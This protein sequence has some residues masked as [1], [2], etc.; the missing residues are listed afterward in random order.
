VPAYAEQRPEN[1][2]ANQT[3]VTKQVWQWNTGGDRLQPYYD[4]ITGGCYG[5][6][7]QI[8]EWSARKWGF[9][10]IGYPD[11]GKAMAV[12]ESNWRQSPKGDY[13]CGGV[14]YGIDWGCDYQ[15][16]GILQVKRSIWPGAWTQSKD[17]TAFNA[18]YALAV[19]RMAYDGQSWHGSAIQGDLW[20]SVAFWYSGGNPDPNGTYATNVRHYN[21]SK[22]WRQ[23]G[24]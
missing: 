11:L 21:D 22:P 19:V 10:Q 13:E 4:K 12:Q 3:R 15:S 17:S 9:D 18:D 16:Y 24:F 14:R 2:L 1:T 20:A 7:E 5:T 8:L 23:T 6:T